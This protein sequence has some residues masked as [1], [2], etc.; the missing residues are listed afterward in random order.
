MTVPG[1]STLYAFI[2]T[3]PCCRCRAASFAHFPSARLIDR[4]ES[5]RKVLSALSTYPRCRELRA[6][7][8]LALKVFDFRHYLK[9]D[10]ML[11]LD[12]DVL[13]FKEPVELLRRLEDPEYRLNSVNGDAMTAYT[14]TTQLARSCGVDLIERFNSGL[15][16]IHRDSLRLDWLEEFLGLPEIVGHFWR[17]E[18]TL[19][20]LCSSRY[21]VELLPKQYDVF[22]DGS[23]DERASRHYVGVIRHLMYGEGIRRMVQDGFLK[24]LVEQSTERK[25]DITERMLQSTS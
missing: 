1:G 2:R 24:R 21:G 11:L 16:L 3:V 10:R 17:I 7:N 25:S 23:V 8:Q 6:T 15:G 13:F 18:Q 5:D 14:V 4:R 22:L 12:S 20:A 9:S 19:Y